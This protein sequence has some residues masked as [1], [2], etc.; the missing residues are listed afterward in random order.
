M[1]IK[2]QGNNIFGN[3]GLKSVQDRMERQAKRDN[4]ISF[5]E[6]R[7]IQLKDMKTDSIE[8]ISRK[9]EML[10]DYDD[11]IAAAKKAYNNSQVFHVLDE[12]RERGEKIAEMAEKF[13][14]KTAEER[15]EDMIEEATGVEKNEGMFGDILEELEEVTE[16]VT[17]EMAEELKEMTDETLSETNMEQGLLPGTNGIEGLS[18]KEIAEKYKRIDYRI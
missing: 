9:L 11:Q 5:L 12:A 10:H 15:R 17:E 3:R 13:A 14:S 1:N 6:Q 4:Q 7:K 8:D 16:E 2:I 18:A